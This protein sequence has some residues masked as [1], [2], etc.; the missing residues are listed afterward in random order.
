VVMP[1]NVETRNIA[2]S[3]SNAGAFF[4]R[5]QEIRDIFDYVLIDI[6][7][8]PSLLHGAIYLATD[9]MVLCTLLEKWSVDGLRETLT[10]TE[11]A[12]RIRMEANFGD[13]EIAGIL[14]NMYRP[15][16]I[17]ADEYLKH[18]VNSYEHVLPPLRDRETFRKAAGEKQLV[19]V[20]EPTSD[21]AV[22]VDAMVYALWERIK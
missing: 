21:A 6:S 7:P 2:T 20:L 11:E 22:D 8:T 13:V 16:R 15:G 10:H 5:L 9:Y 19:R 17:E 4:R 18:L 1:S 12:G 14:P 3:I